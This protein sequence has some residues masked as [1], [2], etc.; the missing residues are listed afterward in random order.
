[1]KKFEIVCTILEASSSNSQ[2]NSLGIFE[3]KDDAA[4]KIAVIYQQNKFSPDIRDVF[5]D[6]KTLN[7]FNT[8]ANCYSSYRIIEVD[9]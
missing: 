1:M 9:E 8:S 2:K 5:F 4:A 7:M 3:N 6:G